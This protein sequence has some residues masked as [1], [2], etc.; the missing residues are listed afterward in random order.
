[1]DQKMPTRP[2]DPKT[3]TVVCGLLFIS[4]DRSKKLSLICMMHATRFQ[5]SQYTYSTENTATHFVFCVC[6][7]TDYISSQFN[8]TNQQYLLGEI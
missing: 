1:M 5:S 2:L 8:K 7:C 6:N 3:M 4:I